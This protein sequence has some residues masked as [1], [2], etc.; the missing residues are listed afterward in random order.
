[1][2][3]I[4][5]KDKIAETKGKI[6]YD[7]WSGSLWGSIFKGKKKFISISGKATRPI[8]KSYCAKLQVINKSTTFV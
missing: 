8:K 1:M 6:N 2:K 5:K 3:P 4:E 7:M